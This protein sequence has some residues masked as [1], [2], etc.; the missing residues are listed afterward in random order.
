MSN[1]WFNIFSLFIYV[2]IALLQRNGN[3]DTIWYFQLLKDIGLQLII[4]PL[5]NYFLRDTRASILLSLFQICRA[6]ENA[7]VLMPLLNLQLARRLTCR[8]VSVYD[9]TIFCL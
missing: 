9:I 2:N 8:P 5:C 3:S 4:N 7:I 6:S 1:F